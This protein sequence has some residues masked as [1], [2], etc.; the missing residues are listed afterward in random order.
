MKQCS[1]VSLRHFALGSRLD[2]QH[3]TGS[4]VSA[5]KAL[6]Q[7]VRVLTGRTETGSEI[8]AF[9]HYLDLLTTWNLTH[10]ITG[11]RSSDAIVRGLFLDSLL[12]LPPLPPGSITVLD[13]GSGSGIPGVPLRIVRPDISLTLIE[14]K[15]KRVSFLASLKRA[16]ALPNIEILEGRAEQMLGYDPSLA[17]K[18]DVV[19]TRAVSADLFPTARKYVKPG[20]LFVAG[21]AP[22]RFDSPSSA[23]D[24][25]T[26][27][28]FETRTYPSLGLS[29]SFLIFRKP[30]EGSA[31]IR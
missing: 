8:A 30:V 19:V 17:G 9:Q 12:F 3:A 21:S 6:E 7:A 1:T 28:E 31:D 13:I 15:R 22:R 14:S 11:L 20:G 5:F 2:R 25:D 4:S 23:Y 27:A 29:R 24:A 10:R 18:F 16:I 26:G